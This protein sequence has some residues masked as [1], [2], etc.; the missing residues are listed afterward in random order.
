MRYGGV[1]PQH[2]RHHHDDIV[3]RRLALRGF[4]DRDRVHQI[5]D[6]SVVRAAGEP[7][8]GLAAVPGSRYTIDLFRFD[9]TLDQTISQA[10]R[11]REVTQ[12]DLA[13][14]RDEAL[15]DLPAGPGPKEQF[16][17]LLAQMPKP[18]H[19]PVI[20]GLLV[21]S[22][23]QLWVLRYEPFAATV[24]HWDVFAPSGSLVA[25]ATTPANVRVTEIGAAHILG[26]ETDSLDV[27]RVVVVF[28]S[29]R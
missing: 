24:Q 6:I 5:A 2:V 8:L 19:F 25:T 14:Y 20:D 22:E 15:R 3:E 16:D 27:P 11:Q 13:R 23:S 28:L 7:R 4:D 12:A 1:L 10:V 18:A 17:Q 9:G 21:D 29:R 26:V